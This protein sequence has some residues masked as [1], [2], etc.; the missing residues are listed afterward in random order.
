[1]SNHAVGRLGVW[2]APRTL[3]EPDGL[4]AAAAE[5]ARL[6]YG[7]LWLGG[8]PGHDLAVPESLLA[9][10][11]RLIVATGVARI[12]DGPPAA[13][14]ARHRELNTR[15][16]GRFLLGLGVS[17]GPAVADYSHP[18]RRMV[19]FLDDLDAAG[20]PAGERVLAALGPRMLALAGERALGA[21]PYLVTPEHTAR[22][23]A[24]LGAGP[25]LA[26][27]QKVVLATD[28]AAARR[29]ARAALATYLRLPNYVNS[30]LR[31]GFT[32]DDVAGGGS[33]RLVDALVAWGDAET[34][35]A[36]LDE[37]HAAGAD[38][39]AVQ[40]LTGT[41]RV[42]VAEWAAITAVRRG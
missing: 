37:H 26:P 32:D 3:D 15:Y 34:V 24:A 38:H 33:D 25:L 17:H 27:E 9:A 2:I 41:G 29:I 14:A 13:L 1:M 35:A 7:A 10:T 5:L 21:H 31:L 8:S 16:G 22:A 4:P 42:P 30:L 28:P 6:G 19:R 20:V 39:V 11:E 18:Y 36:R 12:W 40:V 23:R